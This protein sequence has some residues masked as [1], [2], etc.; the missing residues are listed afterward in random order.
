MSKR[1]FK[2]IFEYEY[3]IFQELH[4]REIVSKENTKC[5]ASRGVFFVKLR[6]A[7]L[8]E[9]NNYREFTLKEER[10]VKNFFTKFIIWKK[11]TYDQNLN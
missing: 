6:N 7:F 4:T 10:F 5:N 3:I 8:L 11:K 1:I 9:V 2:K